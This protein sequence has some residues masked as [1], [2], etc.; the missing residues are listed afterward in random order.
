VE[1]RLRAHAVAN[2]VLGVVRAALIGWSEEGVDP[3]RVTA[4][5]LQRM[6]GSPFDVPLQSMQPTPPAGPVGG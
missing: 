5:L 6:F 2:A 1:V 4:E 3:N